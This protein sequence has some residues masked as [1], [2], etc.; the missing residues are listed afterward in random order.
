MFTKELDSTGLV[1]PELG[2]GTYLFQGSPAVLRRAVDLLTASSAGAIAVVDQSQI[3][4]LVTSRSITE[5]VPPGE[6]EQ[7]QNLP[8]SVAMVSNP[9]IV[10]EGMRLELAADLLQKTGAP[11]LVVATMYGGY[12]GIVGRTELLSALWGSLKYHRLLEW[13]LLLEFT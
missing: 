7:S 4:G 2:F 12:L 6:F 3:V 1:L 5:N 11:A 13:Q 9:V 8:V 10:E